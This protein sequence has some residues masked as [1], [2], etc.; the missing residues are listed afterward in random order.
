MATGSVKIVG[1]DSLIKGFDTA[2]V[3][4]EINKAIKKSVADLHRQSAVKTPVDT[5]RLKGGYIERAKGM[6][7]ELENPIEYGVYVHEGTSRMPKRPFMQEGIDAATS[8]I[9]RHFNTAMQN[10]VKSIASK[11]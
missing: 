5:G 8:S 10:I 1:L 9:E 3:E 2:P 11:R 6:V 7:G 4:K